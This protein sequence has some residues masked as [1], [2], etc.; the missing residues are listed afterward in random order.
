VAKRTIIPG[1]EKGEAGCGKGRIE[2]AIPCAALERASGHE[3]SWRKLS[4]YVC[5]RVWP[6]HRRLD[7]D[8]DEMRGV[9]RR[10]SWQVGYV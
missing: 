1:A 6:T 3:F 5:D 8:R 9:R 7:A 10:A 4:T 2:I